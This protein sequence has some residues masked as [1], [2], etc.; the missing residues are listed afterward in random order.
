MAEIFDLDTQILQGDIERARELIGKPLRLRQYNTEATLDT[1][2]HYAEGIGDDN[3]LWCDEAYANASCQG[4]VV[5]P[6]TWVISVFA[7]VGPGF[8]GIHAFHGTTRWEVDRLVR[9][10]ERVVATAK[11]IGIKEVTGRK[12]GAMIVESGQ[13]DYATPDGEH[14]ATVTNRTIRVP[15]PSAGGLRYEP[16]QP[17]RYTEQEIDQIERHVVA[18]TRRG[19]QQ[20]YWEDVAVGDELPAIIKGPLDPETG[21]A[22]YAGNLQF[23]YQSC[24]LAWK[25]RWAARNRPE[26]VP[27]VRPVSWYAQRTWAGV[28]HHDDDI[29]E[30]VG[31]P[32]AYD[33]GW[34]R[35]AW[36]SQVVTDWA[37]DDSL[38]RMHECRTILPNI[39]GDTL[40]IGA[41]V[42]DKPVDGDDHVVRIEVVAKRQ[43]GET[44]AT[45]NAEVVLPSASASPRGA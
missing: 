27:N 17:H 19:A 28:G 2:R 7:G 42:V 12:G 13:A 1:I 26:T 24:D 16:Q 4:S 11:L 25:R 44:S 34:C 14:L 8:P 30:T 10:G 21:I 3:P 23:G 45:A 9:R 15:R 20:R 36:L 29:A 35:S 18:Q 32:A 38:L 22:Y 41:T 6:P 40:R 37:G 5:A 43:D 31:M 33:N 39:L